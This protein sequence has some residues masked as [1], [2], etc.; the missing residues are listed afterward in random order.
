M[1]PTQPAEADLQESL[2]HIRLN[3]QQVGDAMAY[4]NFQS[5]HYASGV[6]IVT[7]GRVKIVMQLMSDIEKIRNRLDALESQPMPEPEDDS[8][9][10]RVRNEETLRRQLQVA[11]HQ[12][13]QLSR[14]VETGAIRWAA[15]DAQKEA[16]IAQANRPSV[17]FKPLAVQ[18][19]VDSKK[20]EVNEPKEVN[21][22]A[23]EE[24]G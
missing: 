3:D 4:S 17:G 20:V 24:G 10:A 23:R 9:E 19:N 11:I 14:D 16:V 8:Y 12:F 6:K 1:T 18:I 22:A 13:K 7:G 15:V 21:D 2:Q 5:R